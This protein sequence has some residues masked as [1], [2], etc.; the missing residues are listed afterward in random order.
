MKGKHGETIANMEHMG[1]FSQCCPF[2][3]IFVAMMYLHTYNGV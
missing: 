2:C 3:C 1:L